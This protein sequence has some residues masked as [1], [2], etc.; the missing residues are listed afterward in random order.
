MPLCQAVIGRQLSHPPSLG[1]G[2]T[3]Q[4]GDSHSAEGA[5]LV[6]GATITTSEVNAPSRW[7]TGASAT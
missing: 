2:T 3:F 4:T 6:K 1:R 7:D 5:V